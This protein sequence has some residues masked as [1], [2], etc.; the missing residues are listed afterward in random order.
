MRYTII[1]LKAA[2]YL[3]LSSGKGQARTGKGWPLRRKAWK[4]KTLPRAYIKVGWHF[5]RLVI[6]KIKRNRISDF[7]TVCVLIYSIANN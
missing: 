7:V 5:P 6:V 3:L 1:I 2:L 4:L